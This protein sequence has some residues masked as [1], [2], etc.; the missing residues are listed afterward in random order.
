MCIVFEGVE[1]VG[2]LFEVVCVGGVFVVMGEIGVLSL[3]DG[4]RF[5]VR[6]CLL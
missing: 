2:V 4:E 1:V 5:D 3:V 6:R